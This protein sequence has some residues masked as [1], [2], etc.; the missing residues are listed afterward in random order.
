MPERLLGLSDLARELGVPVQLVSNWHAR[1]NGRL[2]KPSYLGPNG[3]PLWRRQ[4][5]RPAL[6]AARVH[7]ATARR[8]GEGSL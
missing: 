2:P 6:E 7:L 5:I 1:D 3:A 4:A 8:N